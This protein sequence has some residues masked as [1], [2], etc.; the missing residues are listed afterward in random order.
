[1]IMV[2]QPH[3]SKFTI[4]LL[5]D[6]NY[7]KNV[8]MVSQPHNSKLTIELLKDFKFNNKRDYGLTTT[9]QQSHNRQ[10]AGF[11]ANNSN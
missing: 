5:K 10:P 4:E 2:S 7:N 8:I 6:F 9:Q 11:K 3:N 1:M